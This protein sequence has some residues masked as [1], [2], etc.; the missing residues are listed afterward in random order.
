MSGKR[1]SRRCE[2]REKHTHPEINQA[3]RLGAHD[4]GLEQSTLAQSPECSRF[5]RRRETP[6]RERHPTS[7]PTE[8]GNKATAWG[9]SA[10]QAD[11]L[12]AFRTP[13]SVHLTRLCLAGIQ[14]PLTRAA[15][16]LCKKSGFCAADFDRD[17]QDA[18]LIGDGSAY[19]SADH[20]HHPQY[21]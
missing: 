6:D 16:L 10:G 8:H 3:G 12:E 1:P 2:N 7:T 18:L 15:G 4:L 21:E 14:K 19:V 20:D 9:K 13:A 11:D 5:V 17:L